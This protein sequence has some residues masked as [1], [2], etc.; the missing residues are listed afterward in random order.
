MVC[1]PSSISHWQTDKHQLQGG[2]FFET[3]FTRLFVGGIGRWVFLLVELL[4]RQ[5]SYKYPVFFFTFWA[6]FLMAYL[7]RMLQFFF[8]L[9]LKHQFL[10]Y[11]RDG[12]ILPYFIRP[13]YF[14]CLFFLF[15]KVGRRVFVANGRL[16]PLVFCVGHFRSSK[17]PVKILQSKWWVPHHCLVRVSRVPKM[18]QGVSHLVFLWPRLLEKRRRRDITVV[19][20]MDTFAVP[21]L[22]KMPC[23]ISRWNGRATE[24]CVI[25]ITLGLVLLVFCVGHP[26][27]HQ[28]GLGRH[29]EWWKHLEF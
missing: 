20:I 14:G 13:N 28:L 21:M 11:F 15:W 19:Q 24:C 27:P 5:E 9:F 17:V 23:P 7:I 2:N 4:L 18:T 26:K 22:W 25:K 6:E 3:T 8:F 10:S 1:F 12:E 16:F 29:V